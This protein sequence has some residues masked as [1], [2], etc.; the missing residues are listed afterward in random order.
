MR[1]DTKFII[2]CILGI[3]VMIGAIIYERTIYNTC[4]MKIVLENGDT[5]SAKR[6]NFY[7]SG[8]SD[9]QMCNGD[10]VITRTSNID[11]IINI[12]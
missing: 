12:K 6:V 11:T 2:G 4:S 8:F 3:T 1:Y 7:T 9:I 5:C 10:R